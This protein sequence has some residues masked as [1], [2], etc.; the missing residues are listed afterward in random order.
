MAELSVGFSFSIREDQIKVSAPASK[1][2]KADLK[3]IDT[4]LSTSIPSLGHSYY[5]LIDKK[6]KSRFSLPAWSD[7]DY[8]TRV[9]GLI[10]DSLKITIRRTNVDGNPLHD[11]P[12]FE[13]LQTFIELRQKFIKSKTGKRDAV[14]PEE[15]EFI[16]IDWTQAFNWLCEIQE[17][18][19]P[20][21]D[22][23]VE[24]AEQSWD[25]VD[26]L[27]T[28]P[29]RILRR[30]R[31]KVNLAKLEEIDDGCL[32]WMV[33]QPGRN[34]AE[35]AGSDQSLLG[36]VRKDNFDT[37]ENRVLREFCLKAVSECYFYD[38]RH[39]AFSQSKRRSMVSRFGHILREK[40][41]QSDV[42]LA[43]RLKYLMEPNFVLQ[44]DRNY[45]RIWSWFLMLVRKQEQVDKAKLWRGRLWADHCRL[46][47]TMLLHQ[48][49]RYKICEFPG[50]QMW[51]RKEQD[52][53]MWMGQWGSP[54]FQDEKS[55]KIAQVVTPEYVPN[56]TFK[57]T[58]EFQNTFGTIGASFALLIWEM[59][60]ITPIRSIFFI[61]EPRPRNSWQPELEENLNQLSEFSDD[62]KIEMRILCPALEKSELTEVSQNKYLS[63]LEIPAGIR[64]WNGELRHRFS[65]KIF[66]GEHFPG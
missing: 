41:N 33:R 60:S 65:Q 59:G 7:K 17:D 23:I 26:R 25:T 46:I 2:N 53:G 14:K 11:E 28:Y 34:L 58:S 30:E 44:F 21:Y 51:L 62:K 20:P 19:E 18:N 13:C 5:D 12:F 32:R 43:S 42:R 48:K 9:S 8:E 6:K 36:I 64:K 15:L 31:K 45:R 37:F 61:A 3:L 29:R 57:N 52:D 55:K 4:S 35:R 40:E 49:T 24:I 27:L 39:L 54:V 66:Q 10:N 1:I 22:P 50:P 56:Y 38:Q 63:I 16:P 47:T